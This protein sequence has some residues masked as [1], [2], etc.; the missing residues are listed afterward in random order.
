MEFEEFKNCKRI[1]DERY[2][3]IALFELE[4][5]ERFFIEPNFYTQLR[6]AK[7]HFMKQYDLIIETM[8]NIV[9]RNKRIIFT[10][11]YEMPVV[12]D[13]SYYYRE[14]DDVLGEIGLSFDIKSNPHSDWKD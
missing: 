2:P 9:K 11:D 10:A 7:D 1:E 8:I 6:Y 3:N 14:L 13:D 5:G 4:T 12:Y